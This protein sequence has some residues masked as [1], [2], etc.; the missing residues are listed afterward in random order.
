MK[1]SACYCTKCRKCFW[2]LRE[3]TKHCLRYHTTPSG[4]YPCPRC[5]QTFKIQYSLLLHVQKIKCKL[6]RCF[7][8]SAEF[9]IKKK[10]LQHEKTHIK[11]LQKRHN[12]KQVKINANPYIVQKYKRL[13]KLR[14]KVGQYDVKKYIDKKY[15]VKYGL[16][17]DP[18]VNLDSNFV[19]KYVEQKC[20]QSFGLL[21]EAKIVL[22]PRGQEL[23]VW[24]KQRH[25]IT[26]EPR[27]FLRRLG[28]FGVTCKNYYIKQ[29]TVVLGTC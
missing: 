4:N 12:L 15:K 29:C 6:L 25:G 19:E 16:L 10:L 20:K 1:P 17:K 7:I 8:C 2:S 13:R 24:Q 22:K 21:Q 11:F 26:K 27:I 9:S 5:Q 3:Y 18:M 14:I 23:D 28:L